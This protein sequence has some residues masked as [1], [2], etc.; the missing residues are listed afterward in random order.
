MSNVRLFIGT[1]K[2]AFVAT[3]DANRSQWSISGPHF[4]GWEVFHVKASPV[5]PDRVYASVSTAW[6]G[7]VVQRSDDGGATWDVVGWN[8]AAR[9]TLSDY[10]ALP[11]HERNVLRRMFLDPATREAQDDWDAVA[12]F[13]V[14]SFRAETARTGDGKRAA[15]LIAELSTASPEFR[16]MWLSN[17]VR[18]TGDGAKLIRH[19]L[20]GKIALEFSSF[21]VDGRPD[22]KLIVY[23]PAGPDD[24][25]KIR[26]LVG[27]GRNGAG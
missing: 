12:R 6:H 15:D 26:A 27:S 1:Q 22:L 5:D 4:G 9:Q 21:A 13:L 23:T 14:A 17:D 24:R 11:P 2:G 7:Q 20:V 19:G 18:T 16:R 3:S 25:E 10:S 8:R